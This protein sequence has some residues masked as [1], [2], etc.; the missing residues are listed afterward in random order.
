MED[1]LNDGERLLR[2]IGSVW[3]QISN[4]FRPAETGVHASTFEA[5][6]AKRQHKFDKEMKKIE[7]EFSSSEKDR[8]SRSEPPARRAL[9]SDPAF[10][11]KQRY[12]E[13]QD[14]DMD[15]V[16]ETLA[17]IKLRARQMNTVIDASN[18]R[19]EDMHNRTER[20]NDRVVHQTKLATQYAK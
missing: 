10:N 16:L 19:L 14:K 20:T 9:S 3:G 15:E 1:D 12:L 7:N 5:E 2:S 6:E 17:A 4:Y 13:E 8:A 11:E 18:N